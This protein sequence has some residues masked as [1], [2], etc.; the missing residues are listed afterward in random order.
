ML[1]QSITTKTVMD[2]PFGLHMTVVVGRATGNVDIIGTCLIVTTWMVF[3]T[4]I[5]PPLLSADA[6]RSN[7]YCSFDSFELQAY[8]PPPKSTPKATPN[9]TRRPTPNPTRKPTPNPTRKP[10]PNPTV[11]PT[12]NPTPSPTP[13]PTDP[14]TSTCGDIKSGSYNGVPVQFTINLPFKG[15]LK[16]DAS[17]STFPISD[18]EAYILVFEVECYIYD[19]FTICRRFGI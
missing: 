10:S 14:G 18:V 11:K 4:L 19:S 13:R 7:E 16:F 5:Y 15:D 12:S 2:A 9:P 6:T 3:Y 8:I 17:P 1:M